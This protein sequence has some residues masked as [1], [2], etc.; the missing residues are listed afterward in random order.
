[1]THGFFCEENADLER[2]N[3]GTMPHNFCNLQNGGA[4]VIVFNNEIE[5]RMR[6]GRRARVD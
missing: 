1:M 3:D 5:T 6:L 2:H 4:S